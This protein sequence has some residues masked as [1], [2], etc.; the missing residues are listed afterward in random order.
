[1]ANGGES[2]VTAADYCNFKNGLNDAFNALIDASDAIKSFIDELGSSGNIGSKTLKDAF[3]EFVNNTNQSN[4]GASESLRSVGDYFDSVVRNLAEA[5]NEQVS[6]PATSDKMFKTLENTIPELAS[7]GS[8]GISGSSVDAWVEGLL[9]QLNTLFTN[10][11]QAIETYKSKVGNSEG[12]GY[13]LA[14]TEA[15]ASASSVSLTE[16]LADNEEAI[17]SLVSTY[18]KQYQERMAQVAQQ[19]SE[20]AQVK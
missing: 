1:M 20:G 10:L 9:G 5:N 12:F 2:K 6:P 14:G 7:D 13:K 19:A 15:E 17:K 3:E 18:V 11:N 4:T 16:T 8:I